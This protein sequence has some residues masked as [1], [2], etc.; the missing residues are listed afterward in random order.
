M[1]LQVFGRGRHGY[2]LRGCGA[3]QRDR[4]PAGRRHRGTRQRG[5]RR[6]A[7][8]VPLL[9]ERRVRRAHVQLQ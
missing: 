9:Q 5:H 8:V 6:V 4:P 1:S 7:V 3:R 2:R